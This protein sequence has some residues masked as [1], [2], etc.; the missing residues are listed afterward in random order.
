MFR[1]MRARASLPAVLMLGLLAGCSGASSEPRPQRPEGA[2]LVAESAADLA[3][4]RPVKFTFTLSGTIPGFRVR[5][6]SGV[7]GAQ[8]WARGTVD[9]QQGLGHTE[10]EFTL[11]RDSVVLTDGEGSP[12]ERSAP[13]RFLPSALLSAHDGIGALMR[14]A[15]KLRTE[16]TETLDGVE[17]YRVTGRLDRSALAKLV[18]GV[19]ADA[20]VKFWV[21]KAPPH[22]LRRI[23]IQ[24]P[25]P[26]PNV[27][28]VA[29]QLAL[30]EPT[31]P[32][33]PTRTSTR[34]PTPATSTS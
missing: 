2:E 23:W 11:R 17:T 12:S 10:Y 28:V 8:G 26:R 20:T 16:T 24:L 27:G 4:V 1:R 22:R 19:W 18:P 5:S 33:R 21:A 34:E 15:T 25:P 6:A 9:V 7:A 32:V 29:L 14:A 30:S 13:E 3:T 31:E